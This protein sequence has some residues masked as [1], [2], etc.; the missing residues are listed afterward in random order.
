M[1][2]YTFGLVFVGSVG[3]TLT[4]VWALERAGVTINHRLL[5]FTGEL[6]K[7]GAIGY[8]VVQLMKFL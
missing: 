6:V 3:I 5:S 1:D 8:L 2:I 4:G 7:Y